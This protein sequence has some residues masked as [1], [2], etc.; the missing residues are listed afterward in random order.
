VQIILNG[1]DLISV[2]R[3]IMAMIGLACT[4]MASLTLL[5]ML[6]RRTGRLRTKIAFFERIVRPWT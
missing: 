6:D 1:A 5:Y 3:L 2:T 4:I